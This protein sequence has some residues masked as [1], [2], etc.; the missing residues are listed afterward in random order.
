MKVSVPQGENA[1]SG[2]TKA[3][4]LAVCVCLLFFVSGSIGL[5]YEVAW[6]HIFATIFGNTTYAVS[7][8]ISIFMGGLALGSFCFGKVADRSRRHLLIYALLAAGTGASALLV[9]VALD[10]AESLYGPVFRATESPGL[11]IA[12]Q[13]LVSAIILLVPTFL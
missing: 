3:A 10:L 6:K 11:L 4:V 12:V 13:V 9:P 7:V 8:V 2:R 5:I 1:R